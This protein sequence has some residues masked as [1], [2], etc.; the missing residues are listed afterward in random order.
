MA[1]D[2]AQRFPEESAVLL[3]AMDS[4]IARKA[5][6]RAVGFARKL[7]T[8]DPINQAARQRMIELHI[9]H[10]RKQIRSKRADLGACRAGGRS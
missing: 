9:S 3:Q 1:E 6:K 4:A 7:L 5:Y 2:A 8:L 10:A